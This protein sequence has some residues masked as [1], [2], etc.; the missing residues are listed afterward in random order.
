MACRGLLTVQWSFTA[1]DITPELL[2]G[3]LY[4]RE[5]GGSILLMH[6][7]LADLAWLQ[8]NLAM[9]MGLTREDGSAYRLTSL[10]SAWND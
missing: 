5:R 8:D 2:S 6:T 4:N 9:M 10:T 7:S 3:I 1:P